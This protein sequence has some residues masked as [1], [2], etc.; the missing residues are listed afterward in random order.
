VSGN[1]KLVLEGGSIPNYSSSKIDCELMIKYKSI[2]H[3]LLILLKI[4]M[5]NKLMIIL[6]AEAS[7]SI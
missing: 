2:F 4:I 6:I 7:K 5:L 3:V 1:Q